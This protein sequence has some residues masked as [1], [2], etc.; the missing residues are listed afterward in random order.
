MSVKTVTLTLTIDERLVEA[1]RARARAERITV[2][3]V[4]GSS[5][6]AY[7]RRQAEADEAVRFIEAL[8]RR[9]YTGG[10]TFTRDEMSER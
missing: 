8:Q 10:R 5:L 1:A 9:V 6:E 2:D 4:V 3:E 7:T